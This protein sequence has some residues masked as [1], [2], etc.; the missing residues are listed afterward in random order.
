[1]ETY[2]QIL[3]IAM[4]IFLVLILIEKFYGI[5]KKQDYVPII[6]S[7]S[8]ISAGMANV[9]KSV[10]GLSVIIVSY[11]WMETHFALFHLEAS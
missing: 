6:D 7:V 1:M 4:P 10:L 9:T 8:S 5:F 3:L 11:E 2:G